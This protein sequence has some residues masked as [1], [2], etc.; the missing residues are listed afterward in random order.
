MTVSVHVIILV[1]VYTLC[2][3]QSNAK[4]V[5]LELHRTVAREG[6]HR[7]IQTT[8]SL[9]QKAVKDMADRTCGVLLIEHLP[10]SLYVD[11]FQLHTVAQFG[12]PQVLLASPV[13]IEAPEYLSAPIDLYVYTSV[14]ID[15]SSDPLDITISLPVHV[16]Y[17]QPSSSPEVNDV[18]VTLYHPRVLLNFT[19]PDSRVTEAPCDAFNIS[20]CAW[21]EL[22]YRSDTSSLEL[23]VPVGREQDARVVVFATIVVTVLGASCLLYVIAFWDHY[24]VKVK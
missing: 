16:R 8:V 12:G 10:S 17:H 20:Q 13:D 5:F 9:G 14:V 15:K 19:V 18:L 23:R 6:F 7:D 4:N 11:P 2:L 22:S 21:S 1:V 3:P 24:K